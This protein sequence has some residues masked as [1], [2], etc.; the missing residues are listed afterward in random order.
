LTRSNK[1][2]P[3]QKLRKGLYSKWKQILAEGMFCRSGKTNKDSV[4]AL[5]INIDGNPHITL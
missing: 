1:P 3:P 5:R 4:K 2:I